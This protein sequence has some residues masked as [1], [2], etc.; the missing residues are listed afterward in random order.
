MR[1]TPTGPASSPS[2]LKAPRRFRTATMALGLALAGISG[3]TSPAHAGSNGQHLVVHDP[4][5]VTA[6]IR[7]NGQIWSGEYARNCVNIPDDPA[8]VDENWWKGQID[9]ETYSGWN[10][11]GNYYTAFQFNVPVSQ[12]SNWHHIYLNYP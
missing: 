4:R 11:G 12:P 7:I 8:W 10:C 3:A 2:A 1:L 5:H 6:S 9:V